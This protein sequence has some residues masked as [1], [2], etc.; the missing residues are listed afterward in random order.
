MRFLLIVLLAILTSCSENPTAEIHRTNALHEPEA[1]IWRFSFQ[2]GNEEL[3][4]LVRISGDPHIESFTLL[5]GGEEIHAKEISINGD[6]IKIVLPVFSSELHGRIDSPNLITGKWIN[7]AKKD[8]QIPFI[9]EADKTYLFTPTRI[10]T[11]LS[12]KYHAVFDPNTSESWNAI[13]ALSEDSNQVHA[14]F[15][16]ETGDYR[17]LQGNVVNNK[18]QLGTFDG[19]HAFLFTADVK[20]D[21]LINGTFTS[22][23]HY[24]TSWIAGEDSAFKLRDPEKL[25]WMKPGYDRIDFK[26]PDQNGDTVTW[27]DLDLGGKIVIIDIMGSWC[28]NCMDANRALEKITQNY[29]SEQIEII[30][31]AYETTADFQTA[32]QRVSKM[33]QDLGMDPYFLYG[34]LAKTTEA[35]ADFPMLNGIM[36]FPTL[37]FIDKSGKVRRIYTGFYGPGTGSYYTEFIQRTDSLLTVMAAEG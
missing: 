6:S 15:L 21:S 34:G 17:Y 20:N 37:I 26:M 19:S 2:L 18:L 3:P 29:P 13:L 24:K 35:S 7:K 33:Q 30:P 31:I 32:K 22:G 16:T 11:P 9:G 1:G 5:N 23:I 36:S 10:S 8:Y 14:T 12:E 4:F 28:P 27:D 25:T